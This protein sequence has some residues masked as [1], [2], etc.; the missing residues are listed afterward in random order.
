MSIF[1]GTVR[2]DQSLSIVY[3]TNAADGGEEDFSAT[4]EQADF[5]IYKDGTALTLDAGTITP[6]N[7]STGVQKVVVDLSNDADLTTGAFYQLVLDASDETIDSQAVS[8][9][10]GHWFIESAS[11]KATRL[12]RDFLYPTDSE[13]STTANNA[14][15]SI[16]LTDIV[17]AQTTELA[18]EL[19]AVHDATNDAVWIV[20]VVAF[21][22][23]QATVETLEGG[24]MPATVASGDHVWRVGQFTAT[25]GGLAELPSR[26]LVDSMGDTVNAIGDDIDD[27][28]GSVVQ[29][30]INDASATATG[31][32]VTTTVGS[33]TRVGF[34]RLTS[35]TLEGESRLVSWT[36][37]T[38]AVL[39]DSSMPTALKQFSAAPADS[40]TFDF[41]P[42]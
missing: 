24:E 35:G 19:L 26:T 39:S 28:F 41:R 36:G 33:D 38:V 40:T 7:I 13:I 12:L 8:G 37:T 10:I 20:R 9:Q 5:T 23:P 17:D 2:E 4:L 16:N 3:T 30:S 1:L 11:E 29:D 21:T 32:T 14:A 25:T 18:G 22:Y 15:S 6:S 34:L 31:F 27:L 42:L